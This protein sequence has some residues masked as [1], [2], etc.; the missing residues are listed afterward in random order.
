ML[1]LLIFILTAI[2]AYSL[3]IYLVYLIYEAVKEMVENVKA[4]LKLYEEENKG[5]E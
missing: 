5:K 1:N 2:F 4:I 3:L